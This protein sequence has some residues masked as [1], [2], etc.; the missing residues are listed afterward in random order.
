MAK[1]DGAIQINRG[2]FSLDSLLTGLFLFELVWIGYQFEAH[3]AL[4][5][6]GTTLGTAIIVPIVMKLSGFFG[7]LL[8]APNSV[9]TPARNPVTMKKFQEQSWQFVIHTGMT[10]W[11][12][13]I[14]SGND[15]L[16]WY[17]PEHAW[18]PDPLEQLKHTDLDTNEGWIQ[19]HIKWFYLVQLGIWI[20]TAMLCRFFDEVRKDYYVMMSHHIVTIAL[21]M[22]SYNYGLMRIGLLVLTVHDSSDIVIDLLKMSNYLE[23]ET[24]TA[25]IFITNLVTWVYLRLYC[26][27]FWVMHAASIASWEHATRESLP[28][29][30]WLFTNT[31][32]G[33]LVVLHVYWYALFIRMLIH[34]IRDG[35][36]KKAAE[37]EYEGSD[38]KHAKKQQ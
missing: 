27:P 3:D 21:V 33:V 38:K 14:L 11:N 10:M 31:L 28:Y 18:I 9:E 15:F 26:Y 30:P 6:V 2:L 29:L 17:K 23:R 1:G 13:Y 4:S 37:K 32:L 8:S 24:I 34:L 22:V 20:W 7:T 16:W 12:V 36:S 25:C 5:V 35:S 19:T